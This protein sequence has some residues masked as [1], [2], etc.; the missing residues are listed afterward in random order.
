MSYDHLNRFFLEPLINIKQNHLVKHAVKR[1]IAANKLPLYDG[2]WAE[3]K[4]PRTVDGYRGW[5][6]ACGRHLEL[7]DGASNLQKLSS[8]RYFSID[9]S[10]EKSYADLIANPDPTLQGFLKNEDKTALNYVKGLFNLQSETRFMNF[11]N[12]NQYLR[13]KNQLVNLQSIFSKEYD[14]GT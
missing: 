10:G 4:W 12:D 8:D 5:A 6:S 11:V 2:D 9:V 13:Q 3:A 7:T 14:L 1:H